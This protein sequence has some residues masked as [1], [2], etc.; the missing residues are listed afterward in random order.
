M[1]T[2]D[3]DDDQPRKKERFGKYVAPEERAN[4]V[5]RQLDEFLRKGPKSGLKYNRWQQLAWY[6]VVDEIKRAEAAQKSHD[7][8]AKAAF[9]SL[10]IGFGTIGFWGLVLLA[11]SRLGFVA[12]GIILVAGLVMWRALSKANWL[13]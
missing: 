13:K 6:E 8:L 12:A 3:S 11:G 9:L 4:N 1:S 5:V 7:S 2:S 10:A